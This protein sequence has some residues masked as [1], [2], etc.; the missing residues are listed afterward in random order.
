MRHIYTHIN[1]LIV[2]ITKSNACL[3]GSMLYPHNNKNF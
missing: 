2:D 3:S 1:I